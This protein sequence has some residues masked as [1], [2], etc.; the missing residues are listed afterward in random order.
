M[1]RAALLLRVAFQVTLLLACIS[2]EIFP[3]EAGNLRI[4]R[5]RDCFA[6]LAVFEDPETYH[7]SLKILGVRKAVRSTKS[8]LKFMFFSSCTVNL[9][10]KVS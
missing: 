9:L 4:L 3:E 1:I 5:T 8:S 6:L 2:P 7:D 10:Y